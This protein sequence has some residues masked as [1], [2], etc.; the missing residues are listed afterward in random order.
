MAKY[1]TGNTYFMKYIAEYYYST[2]L[3][4]NKSTFSCLLAELTI[5]SSLSINRCTKYII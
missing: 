3:L 2:I 5:T 4:Y 1:L